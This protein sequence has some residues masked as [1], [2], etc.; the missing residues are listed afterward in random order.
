ME[1]KD[2]ILKKLQSEDDAV[3]N[4]A[5][6]AVK[7]EGNPTIIAA[8]F[9]ILEQEKD[10]S[11]RNALIRMLSDIK[12]DYK[13]L[14]C[15]RLQATD[16]PEMSRNL[17]RICWESPM[18]F[19]DRPVFIAE[20]LKNKDLN[21]VIEA[22]TVLENLPALSEE[23]RKTIIESLKAHEFEDDKQELI[24]HLLEMLSEKE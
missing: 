14:L 1:N 19:S 13:D 6:E 15:A 16:N 11:R 22:L 12:E 24:N 21:V 5:L 7:K 9:D 8:L 18:D 2:E 17:L 10:Y 3:F 4:E 23:D 20:Y